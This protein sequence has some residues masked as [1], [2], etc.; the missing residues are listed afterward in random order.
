MDA[1]HFVQNSN[2]LVKRA[3]SSSEQLKSQRSM[4]MLDQFHSCIHDFIE[5]IVNVKTDG[6][7]E[8]RAIVTLL[9]MGED[10]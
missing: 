3:A 8:Y 1:L 4:P 2:S 6:N 10:S 5:N 9:G 7:C